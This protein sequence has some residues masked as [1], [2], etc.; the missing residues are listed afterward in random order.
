LTPKINL[1][2]NY[3]TLDD[4]LAANKDIKTAAIGAQYELSKRTVAYVRSV[5]E[6][7]KNQTTTTSAAQL[8]GAYIGVQHN[9]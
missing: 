6:K 9:F 7:T 8:K 5:S 4:K 1:L 3:A 2:A